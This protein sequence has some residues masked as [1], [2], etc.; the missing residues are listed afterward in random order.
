VGS[1][2]GGSVSALRLAEK[3]YRVTVLEAGRRFRDQDFARSSWNLRRYFW[4]P[5]LGLRGIMRLTLFRDIFIVSGAGVG[6]GSLVYANTLY[7]PHSERFY[8]DPTWSALADWRAEL[9]PFYETAQRMLGVTEYHPP[10]PQDE[11]LERLATDLG[12]PDGFRMTK[13]GV[14]LGAPGVEV[15]DPYFGG[16]GP[17]RTGCVRCGACMVGC[18]YGA[19]NTLVKNYLWF[20]ERRGARVEANSMVT[21]IRP[22]DAASG[23]AGYEVHTEY[24]G[25]WLRRRRR[26]IRT[27]G[28]VLAAG[29]LGTTTLLTACRMQG[30]LPALSSRVG[31]TVRT[32]SESILA[33]SGKRGTHDFTNSV[34][35]SSS[36]FPDEHTHI[37]PVTYGARGDALAVL[38]TLLVGDGSRVTRPLKFLGQV[39]RH[40]LRFLALCVP[41]G[42][43]RRTF[44]VLVMQSHDNSMRLVGGRRLFSRRV[45]LRT[46]QDPEHPN[47]TFIP[48]ANQAAERIAGYIDGTPQSGIFEALFNIP[49]TAHLLGGATIGADAASGV[50]DAQHRVFGY[51]NMLVVDGSAIPA[52]VGVNPSLTITALAERAMSRIPSAPP[53]APTAQPS[54]G[55]A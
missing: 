48:L 9:A 19:K 33:V 10:G 5:R 47:P 2:F 55:P 1:G 24:P 21:D 36:I 22:I 31:Y 8:G 28:V 51:R 37:E 12:V 15:P 3:G 14:F 20:A 16:D 52:N 6:G 50:V 41:F 4:A 45:R 30:G 29:A 44:L 39:V 7:V 40:P 46:V 35:I 18:R 53:L 27:R 25:A 26:V 11:L 38:S 54:V 49:T 34:A 23:E 42:W 13:V 17:D 43:A 32:N